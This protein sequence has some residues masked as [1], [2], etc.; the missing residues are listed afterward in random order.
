MRDVL[1]DMT[2]QLAKKEEDRAIKTSDKLE[3]NWKVFEDNVKDKYTDLYEKV[4][5]PLGAFKQ[6]LRSNPWTV[7]HWTIQ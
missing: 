1:K 5:K 3:E 2:D 6:P 7:K 4:E